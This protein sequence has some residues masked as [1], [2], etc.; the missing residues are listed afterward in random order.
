MEVNDPAKPTVYAWIG[1]RSI[2]C[3]KKGKKLMFLKSEIDRFFTVWM[4]IRENLVILH[5][6]K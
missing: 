6:D 3:H 2:P 5:P 1:Q 4:L